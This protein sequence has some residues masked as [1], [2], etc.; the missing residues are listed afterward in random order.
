M[1][2]LELAKKNRNSLFLLLWMMV[3]PFISTTAI[4]IWAITNENF[5]WD[6]DL[7]HWS[8]FYMAAIFT[9]A[10]AITSTTFLAFLGGY[11]LAETAIPFT[12][13]SYLLASYL[14]YSLARFM[15]KGKFFE[16]ISHLPKASKYLNG[17]KA[18]QF[19]IVVL[20]R[21]SPVLPFAIINVV[22]SMIGVK[23]KP[24]LIAGFIGILPRIL[25]FMWLG[26][27][28]NTL[29]ELI[30]Q[31]G[32]WPFQVAFF[33]L[34]LISIVGFTY[35]MMKIYARNKKQDVK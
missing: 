22:L 16:T 31:Q 27:Q 33:S 2:L 8:L 32:E 15:D 7:F 24:F 30:R 19:G 29:R 13:I 28:A 9:M 14:G 1:E 11:F 34:L 6:L 23:I 35:Y 17:L 5:F 26:A 25:F 12:L 10:F 4:G 3:V 18:D 21:I 20:S